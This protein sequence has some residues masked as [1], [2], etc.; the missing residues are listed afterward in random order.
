MWSFS[1]DP[2]NPV[3][4]LWWNWG[5]SWI[6]GIGPVG[7]AGVGL[8]LGF[9]KWPTPREHQ[10]VWESGWLTLVVLIGWGV[11]LIAVVSLFIFGYIGI[12]H[13]TQHRSAG[14]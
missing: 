7:R 6:L 8:I 9:W 10:R 4:N 1:R 11:A 2:L 13:L 3:W 14:G 12:C 5:W